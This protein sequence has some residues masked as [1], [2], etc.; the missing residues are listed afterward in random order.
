MQEIQVTYQDQVLK[1]VKGTTYYEIAKML[2]LEDTLA[3]Q[4]GNEVFS[5]DAKISENCEVSFLDVT[6]LTG[7]KIYQGALKF[8]FYVLA[9]WRKKISMKCSIWDMI[10]WLCCFS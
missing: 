5:L 9:F 3:A 4:V 10:V 2:G 1:V 8:L 7:Y 6:S